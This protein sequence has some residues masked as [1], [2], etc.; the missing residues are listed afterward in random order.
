MAYVDKI[1][2]MAQANNYFEDGETHE[3]AGT[4][5]IPVFIQ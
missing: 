4:T 5:C 1:E 2:L 3:R